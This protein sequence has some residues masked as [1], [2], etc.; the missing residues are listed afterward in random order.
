MKSRFACL[1]MVIVLS[2]CRAK[3]EDT[4]N[5]FNNKTVEFDKIMVSSY[6]PNRQADKHHHDTTITALT[7]E[8][9]DKELIREYEEMTATS[10]KTGYCCCP[11][12]NFVISFYSGDDEYNKSHVDTV[13]FKDRV[14][15]FQQFYQT[16]FIVDKQEWNNFLSKMERIKG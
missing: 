14:R 11:H 6:T 12:F 4:G 10:E 3:S 16:S 8:S 13:E 9:Y 5:P 1:V 2:G 7:Y 15:I